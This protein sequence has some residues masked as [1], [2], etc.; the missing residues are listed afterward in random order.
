MNLLRENYNKGLTLQL[1]GDIIIGLGP[2][3]RRVA[4]GWSRG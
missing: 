1:S 4:T 2:L 3:R